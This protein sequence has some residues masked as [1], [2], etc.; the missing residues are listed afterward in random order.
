MKLRYYLRG[1]GTGI[2]IASLIFLISSVFQTPMT[3]AAIKKRAEKLG[4]VEKTNGTT[5]SESE[6]KL[7][8]T[9]DSKESEG[10]TSTEDKKKSG[11]N[12]S[13]EEKNNNDIKESEKKTNTEDKSDS[14]VKTNSEDNKNKADSSS[15]DGGSVEKNTSISRNPDNTAYKNSKNSTGIPFSVTSGDTSQSVGKKLYQR[16]LVDDAGKFSSYMESHNIDEKIMQ[17]NY[18]IPKNATYSQISDIITGK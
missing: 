15:D 16:G 5:I 9:K 8:E 3:D 4:M 13:T 2:I 14:E 11:E 10:K 12:N 1:I 17:G 7:A 18:D 6:K